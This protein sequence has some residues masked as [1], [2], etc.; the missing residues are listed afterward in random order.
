MFQ[1]AKEHHS[2]WFECRMRHGCL[3]IPLLPH[4]VFK[5][6]VSDHKKAQGKGNR[7][8]HQHGNGNFV[9]SHW[10]TLHD[11]DRFAHLY[12]RMWLHLQ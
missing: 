4:S 8:Q 1:S 9:Q 12:F 2:L 6:S 10:R 7:T 11:H 3:P 5:I